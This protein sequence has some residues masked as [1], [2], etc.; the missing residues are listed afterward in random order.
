MLC[1]YRSL[2]I[3]EIWSALYDI[4]KV[5]AKRAQREGLFGDQTYH[6]NRRAIIQLQRRD[7]SVDVRHCA[8]CDVSCVVYRSSEAVGS[9]D[10]QLTSQ[11]SSSFKHTIKSLVSRKEGTVGETTYSLSKVG[12]GIVLPILLTPSISRSTKVGE[13]SCMVGLLMTFSEDTP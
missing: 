7:R 6:W 13:L 3:P 12:F 10:V 8:C 4:Y 11:Q 1:R 2:A 9:R 5:E